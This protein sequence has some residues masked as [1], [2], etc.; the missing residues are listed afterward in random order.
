MQF[1]VFHSFCLFNVNI[2]RIVIMVFGQLQHIACIGPLKSL[3]G[4]EAHFTSGK[5]ISHWYFSTEE[6]DYI[7]LGTI[8]YFLS[9]VYVFSKLCIVILYLNSECVHNINDRV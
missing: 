4:H 1:P 7:P 9:G 3:L 2:L 8:S 5:R 6:D